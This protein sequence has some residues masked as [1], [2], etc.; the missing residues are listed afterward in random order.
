MCV[1]R[2]FFSTYIFHNRDV[3]SKK[4]PPTICKWLSKK[5]ILQKL[6]G[7]AQIFWYHKETASEQ[8]PVITDAVWQ[9]ARLAAADFKMFWS[10]IV[11]LFKGYPA[12]ALTLYIP[13]AAL[14]S[15]LLWSFSIL[16]LCYGN[17]CWWESLYYSKWF[18][19][20]KQPLSKF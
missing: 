17:I 7:I 11:Y 15:C 2:F 3:S 1:L 10:F 6:I 20:T 18:S 16:L 14:F 5:L 13:L 8:C 9:V 19:N 12:G 4:G